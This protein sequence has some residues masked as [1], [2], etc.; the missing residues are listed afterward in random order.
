MALGHGHGS[1]GGHGHGDEHEHGHDNAHAHDNAHDDARGHAHDNGHG[2]GHGHG[3]SGDG[4]TRR[5]SYALVLTGLFFFVEV[6]FGIWTHSLSLMSDAGHMLG[7]SGALVLA[8]I[9]QRIAQRPRTRS[10]TYGY[11]RAEILAALVNG[12]VLLVTGTLIVSEAVSRV[13]E[14]PAVNGTPMLIVAVIGLAVN[15]VS[16]LILG[17]GSDNANVRA[18]LLH[19]LSDALGSVASIVAGVSIIYF[20]AP[21]ADPIA[22]LVIAVLIVIG[23]VRLLRETAHV[24][25]EASPAH[26]DLRALEALVRATPGVSDVHDLHAWAISDGFVAMTVH[27][28]LDGHAHGTDVAQLVGQRVRTRFGITHTTVQPEHP[29][30]GSQLVP[31]DRLLAIARQRRS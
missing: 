10:H 11:R 19:V 14:P 26:L 5:L 23:A 6:G 17:H 15:G 7:D 30:S 13:G 31:V 24:L 16:A 9:A 20:D 8:V 3:L 29:P 21:I 1:G 12:V 2:H 4:A 25:M 22:S 27:V 28:V 18:A